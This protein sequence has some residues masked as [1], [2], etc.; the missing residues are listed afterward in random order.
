M[1][2]IGLTGGIG[3]GKSTVAAMLVAQGGVL[4][5]TDAIARDIAQP[6]GIAMPA[7]E[8]AFGPGV[9]A[10]DG[11]L[12]RA[13]MRQLVFADGHAKKRLESILHP[14]IGAET[15]RLAAAAGPGATVIFDVPLLVESRRWRAIVDRVLVVDASEETQLRRVVARSGWTPEAVRAVIAQQAP[16]PLRR[17]AADAVIFNESL[18][19]EELAAQVQSLWKRWAA[20]TTR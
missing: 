6:G 18:S 16:R 1:R 4:V 20:P 7:I 3:S 12:D 14:L 8:A 17:A 9:I 19:L 13:A 15:E 5:D 10:S 2:R 11:G